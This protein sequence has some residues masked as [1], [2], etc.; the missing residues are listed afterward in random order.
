MTAYPWTCFYGA[1]R[2]PERRAERIYYHQM[3]THLV[4]PVRVFLVLAY[5]PSLNDLI[6]HKTG[7]L[8]RPGNHPVR[9]AMEHMASR[10]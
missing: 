10:E 2:H 3:I 8:R 9:A 4:R 5:L 1:K 7:A 6:H